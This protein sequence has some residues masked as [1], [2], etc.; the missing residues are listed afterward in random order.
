MWTCVRVTLPFVCGQ[1]CG[2]EEEKVCIPGLGC[3][4]F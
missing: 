3:M 1:V 2:G 4:R